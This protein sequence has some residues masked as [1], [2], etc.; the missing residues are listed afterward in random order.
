M[1]TNLHLVAIVISIVALALPAP[2]ASAQ[3]STS[4]VPTLVNFSGTLTD[5][6]SKPLTGTVGVTFYLY[7]E[8]Q[9]GSPLWMETQNVQPDVS[10]R[11]SVMLGSMSSQGL[12]TSLF[13]SGEARWL[14][15]QA[16]GEAEQPRV[17]LLAVPY[18][19][20]A[21]DA[22][23]VGGLPPSA[24]VLAPPVSTSASTTTT[25]SGLNST[26][27]TS[28]S[29]T[30]GK[31]N[32]GG[33][34]TQDYIPIWTDNS[35][36]LG[37]SVLY[38][39]GSGAT[40]MIGLNIKT[41]LASLDINGTQLMRGLFE[42]AT[43]GT[44]NAGKGYSSHPIDQEASSFNSGTNKA[45]M[46][47]FEWQAEPTGNDT[48]NPGATLNLLFGQNTSKPTETG[49]LISNTGAIQSTNPA[50]GYGLYGVGSTSGVY[51]TTANPGSSG[52]IGIN[53][54]TV[55]GIGVSGT[56]LIGVSGTGG[57]GNNVGA[58]G[59]QGTAADGFGVYGLTT[60]GDSNAGVY[61]AWGMPSG[62]HLVYP[63]AGVWGDTGSPSIPGVVGTS[64]NAPGVFGDSLQ[65]DGVDG[66]AGAGAGIAGYND[67]GSFPSYGVYGESGQA[68]YGVYGMADG[69]GSL[70]VGVSGTS[71]SGMGAGVSG[72]DSASGGMGVYGT[73]LMGWAAFFD[74][75]INVTGQIFA[76]IKD[77]RID[78]PLDPAN[79]YLYHA[80]V[81]SSEMLTIY[82]GNVVLG[83]E[84][85]AQVDLPAW[86]EA[87]NRDF[88]YQLTAIG[89][90]GPNLYIAS[91][92]SNGHFNIAGGKAGSKVSWT[93]TA[94][95][96]DPYAQAHPLVVEVEKPAEERGSYLHPELYG[97]PQEAGLSWHRYPGLHQ[98]PPR[99]SRPTSRTAGQKAQLASVPSPQA[100]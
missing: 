56:G 54:S 28:T 85:T 82:S 51:G 59:V 66:V 68:G 6:S 29:T 27:R 44:A 92:I 86:F 46:Q 19:L 32:V 5:V 70:S 10:G 38:Q 36:D 69:T 48:N 100:R 72:S 11:Y 75:N 53:P 61:G 25:G 93:V 81:E 35:G 94:V 2:I 17:M 13:S 26:S 50:S 90:P 79:K 9:G 99:K 64:L 14:G 95:R 22:A 62:F 42:T 80:S 40:A 39:T 16:Q 57:T 7:N 78:H 88:R 55:S 4:V 60:M 73:S 67:T 74:G 3:Q 33:S 12:P 63:G 43:T 37:N 34:G 71:A 47:H 97:A 91:E 31:P 58:I 84:G 45:V 20:K 98:T 49:L 83:A 52:V 87:V 15:V 96:R 21:G 24:F 41:P 18:A 1:K 65:G 76:G 30:K 23:T 89:A 8:Q 77:F